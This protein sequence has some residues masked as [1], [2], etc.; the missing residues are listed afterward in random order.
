MA[1][2]VLKVVFLVANQSFPGS[3]ENPETVTL[4]SRNFNKH[5]EHLKQ[6]MTDQP[7]G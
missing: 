7:C 2:V 1:S 4:E 6:S 5:P 3:I